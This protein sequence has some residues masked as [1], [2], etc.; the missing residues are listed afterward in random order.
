[1]TINPT[2]PLWGIRTSYR[3]LKALDHK[4]KFQQSR[5]SYREPVAITTQIRLA[6]AAS[7]AMAVAI[8]VVVIIAVIAGAILI[9]RENHVPGPIASSSSVTTSSLP[10]STQPLSQSST[11]TSSSQSPPPGQGGTSSTS[12]SSGTSAT[13]SPSCSSYNSTRYQNYIGNYTNIRSIDDLLGNY[14]SLSVE[15]V[16]TSSFLGNASSS[17][18]TTSYNYST[19]STYASTRTTINGTLFYVVSVHLNNTESSGSYSSGYRIYFP[20]GANAT[21]AQ[22]SYNVNGTVYYENL[23]GTNAASLGIGVMGQFLIYQAFAH[24]YLLFSAFGIVQTGTSTVQL[25][26]TTFTVKNYELPTVPTTET[27]CG[28]PISLYSLKFSIGQP[29]GVSMAL[30]TYFHEATSAQAYITFQVLS[31][32]VASY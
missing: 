12:I 21:L 28:E 7:A 1:M 17:T 32:T 22:I 11:P 20:L 23:T 16:G 8:I 6:K 24:F 19:T 4:V 13:T 25:G 26:Q 15:Q 29:S 3:Q 14:S 30:L 31:A 9:Y 10:V 2:W 18:A 27:N 5:N